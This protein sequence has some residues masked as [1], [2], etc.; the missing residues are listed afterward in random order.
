MFQFLCPCYLQ[1]F[2]Y[3]F[4]GEP[5][6]TFMKLYRSSDDANS[7]S[8]TARRDRKRASFEPRM[9]NN[10][11]LRL[12]HVSQASDYFSS[13]R[14]K[15]FT[16]SYGQVLFIMRSNWAIQL[17]RIESCQFPLLNLLSLCVCA[18]A[19][20][21]LLRGSSIQAKPVR[22]LLILDCYPER[23]LK[24]LPADWKWFRCLKHEYVCFDFEIAQS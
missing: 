5:L 24:V 15:L 16:P 22:F 10:L 4:A 1:P 12:S 19:N 20:I 18:C 9:W 3:D 8:G 7:R 21:Q 13:I 2:S 14:F 23:F 17:P 6:E 11:A